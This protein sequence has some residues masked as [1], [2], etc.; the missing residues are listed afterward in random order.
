MQCTQALFSGTLRSLE[1]TGI[2]CQPG[3]MARGRRN[4]KREAAQVRQLEAL[5]HAERERQKAEDQAALD[6][7]LARK[8]HNGRSGLDRLSA[9]SRDLERLHRDE[10]RLLQERDQLVHWL[11]SQGQSWVSLSARTN[12][13]RQALMK[14][15]ALPRSSR[16]N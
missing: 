15:S 8:W 4:S 13:S 1:N 2:R 7:R 12:L 3:Y 16:E 5:E 14:R 9:L 10:T 6:R 11:R